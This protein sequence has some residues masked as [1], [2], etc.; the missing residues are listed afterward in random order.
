MFIQAGT[1]VVGTI[2][3]RRT[4]TGVD[5]I[6]KCLYVMHGFGCAGG[7]ACH[8]YGCHNEI[9]VSWLI[10]SESGHGAVGAGQCFHL[11]C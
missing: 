8:D 6:Y 2:G 5:H 3:M 9:F 4:N 11:G 1:S 10:R 7:Y